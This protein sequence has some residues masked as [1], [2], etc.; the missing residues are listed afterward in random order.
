MAH[1][2]QTARKYTGGIS[3]RKQLGTNDVKK[4]APAT[5]IMKKPHSCTPGTV[6]LSDI[7]RHQNSTQI[8]IDKLPFQPLIRQIIQSIKTDIQF[9]NTA[10]M[11]LQYGSENYLVSLYERSIS[12]VINENKISIMTKDLEVTRRI[13]GEFV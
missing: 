8:I 6:A 7:F 13:F 5:G 1:V 2:K 10:L 4:S 3:P 12:F 11:A 9:D